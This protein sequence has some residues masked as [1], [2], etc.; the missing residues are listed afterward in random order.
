MLRHHLLLYC[1]LTIP[2]LSLVSALRNGAADC[3]EGK[4]AVGSLHLS[5][6]TVTTGPLRDGNINLQLNNVLLAADASPVDLLVGETHTWTLTSNGGREFRGFLLRLNGGDDN[7]DTTDAL[8]GGNS[9]QVARTTCINTYNVGG[10]THTNNGGKSAV[11]GSLLLEDP[12][13]NMLLDVTI[14]IENRNGVSTYYYSSF[15]LNAVTSLDSAAPEEEEEEEDEDEEEADLGMDLVFPNATM[16]PTN[17]TMA[18]SVAE[19]MTETAAVT[20]DDSM[21]TTTAIPSMEMTTDVPTA[22]ETLQ[23]TPIES[24][25]ATTSMPTMDMTPAETIDSS[26]A[27]PTMNMTPEKTLVMTTAVPSMN[28][29]TEETMTMTTVVPSM[30]MTPEETMVM[31]TAVPSMNMSPEETMTT[32]TAVPS[33][34]MPPEETMTTTTAVPSINM[35]SEA[36]MQESMNA[37]A[38]ESMGVSEGTV[39]PLP[40]DSDEAATS[41]PIIIIPLN[42]SVAPSEETMEPSRNMT[43]VD[44]TAGPSDA[45]TSMPTISTTMPPTQVMT[46]T[47]GP[48]MT[49]TASDS[50]GITAAPTTTMLPTQ[51]PSSALGDEEPVGTGTTSPPNVDG[52]MTMLAAAECSIRSPCGLC[53]G[54]SEC[55][56]FFPNF[57]YCGA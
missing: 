27:V 17:G 21:V 1:Y 10:V 20:M 43:T 50:M 29:T 52:E 53:Q 8:S 33:M 45:M 13:P 14:V 18:P 24:M 39:T 57:L 5:A 41:G 46:A 37:T 2:F 49:M 51:M 32:T 56:A 3:P 40:S 38:A 30:N 9:V 34:N 7:I 36:T 31:T 26:T 48:T 15:K 42:E 28:M 25:T 55:N 35:T 16:T 12:S 6:N 54:V 23:T 11:S 44:S 47:G 22:E 19:T 4:P